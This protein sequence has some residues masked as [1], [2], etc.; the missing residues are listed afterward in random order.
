MDETSIP[1]WQ[2]DRKGNVGVRHPNGRRRRRRAARSTLH[3]RRS[4]FTLVAF[5]CDEP[6]IQ[7][8]LPQ[9]CIVNKWQIT[10]TE[11]QEL[12]ESLPP[13]VFVLR[14]K[15]S[16]NNADE[17]IRI[18]ACL[19]AALKRSNLLEHYQPILL[20]DAA[21]FHCNALVAA[22]A[23]RGGI[24]YCLVSASLTWLLQ[25]LDTHGFLKFKEHLRKLCLEARGAAGDGRISNN[26]V[27]TLVGRTIVAVLQGTRWA[28]TFKRNGYSLENERVAMRIKTELGVAAIEPVPT[29]MPTSEDLATVFPKR[30]AVPEEAFL[31]PFR[32]T[33][34]R[35]AS[36]P[37]VPPRA[38]EPALL[39]PVPGL[40][41]LRRTAGRVQREEASQS[42]VLAEASSAAA[43]LPPRSSLPDGR[44]RRTLP[45][46]AVP[47]TVTPLPPTTAH[48]MAAALA[49]TAPH[50]ITAPKATPPRVGPVTRAMAKASTRPPME[51]M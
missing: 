31:M 23:A 28:S 12:F 45:W 47:R 10:S 29:T 27:V 8:I 17:L 18:I 6:S 30:F 46:T 42:S 48:P 11:W 16:W 51:E 50:P 38:K 49:P 15:S 43:P 1:F 13:N 3:E 25:P 24:W 21:K 20:V 19:S 33:C 14:R 34:T 35:P 9:V 39:P 26:T 7:P 22:E 5:I 41:Y 44:P 4:A 36:L 32:N 2:G 40:P 37:P